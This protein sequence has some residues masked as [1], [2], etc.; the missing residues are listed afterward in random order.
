ME[1]IFKEFENENAWRSYP[2][3]GGC[4]PIDDDDAAIRAI[5]S[6]LFVDAALY[7]INPHGPLFLSSVSASGEYAISDSSGVV[8][9]GVASGRHVE[10]YD[11]SGLSRHV[12]TMMASSEEA[13]SEFSNRGYARNYELSETVFASSCVFPIVNDGVMSLSVGGAD[14]ATGVVGFSNGDKDAI[15]VSSSKTAEGLDTLRFDII[16]PRTV[17]DSGSIRR[18]ICVVDGQTPFRIERM[19]GAYN[20]IMLK[21]E[22]IDKDAVC[23]GAH[24]ENA[25]EMADTCE[26]GKPTPLSDEPLPEA[27]QLIEVYIPPDEVRAGMEFGMEGGVAEGADNAFYIVTP[28]LINY[29]NPISITLEDGVISPKTGGLE[30]SVNGMSAEPAEGEMADDVASKGVVIQVPGLSGGST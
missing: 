10:L 18:I 13:L 7:P 16:P 3:A 22:G 26:C 14:K 4:A 11:T 21:L 20:T 6:D 15:R 25:Y 30:I 2:F 8:M 23:A 12:G 28:N 29:G 9:S 17:K 27:Y 19:P 24:R 5:P 1:G